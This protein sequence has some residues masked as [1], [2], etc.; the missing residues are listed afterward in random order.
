MPHTPWNSCIMRMFKFNYLIREHRHYHSS[1]E[2][3]FV[4]LNTKQK[5]MKEH[6]AQ[7]FTTY[8]SRTH[9]I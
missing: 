5:C 1:E 2:V 6:S 3:T 7:T 4:R 8:R 9:R